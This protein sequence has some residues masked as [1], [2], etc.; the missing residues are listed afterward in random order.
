[1]LFRLCSAARLHYKIAN[2]RKD[3]IHKATRDVGQLKTRPYVK[4]QNRQEA[5][6]TLSP[7]RLSGLRTAT[8]SMQNWWGVV[9]RFLLRFCPD[10]GLRP[11]EIRLQDLSC[12]DVETQLVLV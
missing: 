12:I 6:Q 9:A 4:I 11:K 2:I 7:H 8:E 5:I 3:A 1:M 10:S